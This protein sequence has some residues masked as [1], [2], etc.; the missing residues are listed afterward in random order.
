MTQP[1]NYRHE[2]VGVFGYPVDENPTLLMFEAAF[3]ATGLHWRYQNFLV[4]PEALGDAMRGMRAMNFRGVNLTIPHKIAVLPYLD[5]ITPEA[6]LIGAVNTV[7]REGDALVG[8][9]TDGKGF[10]T[11][12]RLRGVSPAG[13]RVALIG[14]GGAARA[15]AVELARA[16]AAQLTIFNR[17]LDRAESLAQVINA[18]TPARA[19]SAEVRPGQ[20]VAIP[21]DADLV[22][23][24]TSLGLYPRIDDLPPVDT[25]TIRPHMLVCDVIPNPP[26]TR[27]LIEA[28]A[29]GAA[30]LDGLSMLVYQ[31][32]IA[33]MLWTGMDA[34]VEAM[35]AALESVFV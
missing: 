15:I 34:P 30:T 7:V 27:F 5:R 14:A 35:R 12:I 1:V 8:A 23:N 10:L 17:T 32:A 19:T 16:G 31:G 3:K 20:R 25:E 4:K 2:I 13:K 28:R 29:K 26:R 33:F 22:I 9:N 21:A 18:H 11:A 6:A 24:A